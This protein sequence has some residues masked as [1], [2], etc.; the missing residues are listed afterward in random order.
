MVG[1]AGATMV[2]SSAAS[3]IDSSTPPM[4][5][6]FSLSVSGAA[7]STVGLVDSLVHIL[8]FHSV[9]GRC[10]R[11]ANGRSGASAASIGLDLVLRGFRVLRT[12]TYVVPYRPIST[13]ARK[14]FRPGTMLRRN[15]LASLTL[16][17]GRKSGRRQPAFLDALDAVAQQPQDA[18][19]EIDAFDAVEPQLRL[20][21]PGE[22]PAVISAAFAFAAVRRSSADSSPSARPRAA[23]MVLGD[24]DMAFLVALDVGRQRVPDQPTSGLGLARPAPP[25]KDHLGLDR[26]GGLGDAAG[27]SAFPRSRGGW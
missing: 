7:A 4:M 6:F 8:V 15:W 25:R 3:S 2:W 17:T 16:I 1:M 20:V 14:F 23:R 13:G 21:V 10:A 18:A 27:A 26:H 12:L 22:Q 5:A 19:F 24:H 11:P 9:C